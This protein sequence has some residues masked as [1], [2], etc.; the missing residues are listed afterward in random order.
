MNTPNPLAAL[1]RWTARVI[2]ALL[3]GLF[4]FFTIAEGLP[5]PLKLSP[6]FQAEF[7]TFALV[8]G[9]ILVGWRWELVGGLLSLV[10]AGL[11]CVAVLSSGVGNQPT[12]FFVALAIPGALYVTSALLRRAD[13][14]RSKP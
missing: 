7:L 2:A 10:S 1:C 4:L 3:L 12:W 6:V 13:I 11:F 9:A 8:F 14:R 5:N